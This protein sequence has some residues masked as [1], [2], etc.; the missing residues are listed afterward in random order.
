M[1]DFLVLRLV[2]LGLVAMLEAC[3]DAQPPDKQANQTWAGWYMA[4]GG[5]KSFQ[6]CGA[7]EALRIAEGAD[8]AARANATGMGK[9]DPVYVKL[10]GH[11]LPARGLMVEKVLQFG[12]STPVQNCAMTGLVKQA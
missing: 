12:S 9:D 1:K 6:P 2:I 5:A 7:S 10:L 3:V 11:T 4:N 8:L